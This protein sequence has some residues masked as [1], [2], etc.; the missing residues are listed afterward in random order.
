MPHDTA[1][2]RCA[3]MA[4][5]R[6]APP[7]STQT[8]MPERPS[9]AELAAATLSHYED[10]AAS[11]RAG[12]LDH[13]V[14]QN[15]DALLRAIES[16]PPF[17]ILDV[18]CGPGRDL[19]RFRALGHEAVGL[20]GAAAF[21]AM[22]RRSTGCEVWWQNFISLDLPATRFDGAFANAALFHTPH[23]ALPGVLRAL[24][25]TLRARG[26]LFCSNPRGN[27]EEGYSGARY[28]C[29]YDL[30]AWRALVTDAGFDEIEHFYRPPGRPRH[31][32]PWL[33]TVWRKI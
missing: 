24:H 16:D 13:D 26:V 28:G 7:A 23:E 29:Y 9:P 3:V 8:T 12:T 30:A 14:S 2:P 18:G 31:E 19:A 33:A 15:I 21:V 25:H 1:G 17:S 4:Y 5:S 6:V 20:D 32:Q 11:Y 27:N 10:N 22:A